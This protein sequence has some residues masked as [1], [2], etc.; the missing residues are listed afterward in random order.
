MTNTSASK[1]SDQSTTRRVT[2]PVGK[3][4]KSSI[5]ITLLSRTK[6][7]TPAEMCTA[8][9]WQQHSARAFLTGLRKKGYGIAREQRGDGATHYR[10]TSHPEKELQNESTS[11]DAK[12]AP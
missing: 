12:R 7:A 4:S 5:V 9:N 10:I 1:P 8:T 11:V 3:V 2:Q 6:G